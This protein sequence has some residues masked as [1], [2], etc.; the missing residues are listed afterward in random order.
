MREKGSAVRDT[1]DRILLAENL[2]ATPV[3]ESI[4]S[5]ALVKA[6]EAGLG[7]A[8][9]PESLLSE[10]VLNHRLRYVDLDV[11]QMKNQMLVIFNSGQYVTRQHQLFLDTVT[12]FI[13]F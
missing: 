4:N 9:L 11:E 5:M 10:P 7:I 2:T 1:F 6:A 8:I 13:N 3:W 12:G